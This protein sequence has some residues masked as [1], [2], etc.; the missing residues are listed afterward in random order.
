MSPKTQKLIL[1]ILEGW[2]TFVS[3]AIMYLLAMYL[4]K[5]IAQ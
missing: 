4:I 3:I 1:A 2:N 5:Y